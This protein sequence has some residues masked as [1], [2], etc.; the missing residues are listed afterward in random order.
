MTQKQVIGPLGHKLGPKANTGAINNNLR[1]LDRSGKPCKRWAKKGIQLKSFTGVM[2]SLHTWRTPKP[3]VEA[4]GEEGVDGEQEETGE[5]GA[6]AG[7]IRENGT[8]SSD[9]IG[10]EN[11]ASDAV[12]NSER[13]NNG[14]DTSMALNGEE[15]NESILTVDATVA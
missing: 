8:V 15:A 14:N 6:E 12:S 10:K 5:A 7:A 1:A 13:S 3:I 4:N 9:S 11:H 2:W